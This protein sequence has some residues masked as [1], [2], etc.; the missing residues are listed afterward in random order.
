M[1]T[2]RAQAAGTAARAIPICCVLA[3]SW[4]ND[5]SI[6]GII[7]E[8]TTKEWGGAPHSRSENREDGE[9]ESDES[10]WPGL[11][12]IVHVDAVE[13]LRPCPCL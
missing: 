11:L 12:L 6:T 7:A 5:F 8:G 3:G 13:T 2:W 4:F 9:D 1:P 10:E